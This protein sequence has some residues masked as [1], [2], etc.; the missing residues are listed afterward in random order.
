MPDDDA[1][2]KQALT[3]GDITK[4]T[5]QLLVTRPTSVNGLGSREQS[6]ASG[7]SRVASWKRIRTPIW[8]VKKPFDD[9]CHL[10]L[11]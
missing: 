3:G 1:N 9:R 11:W 10:E 4:Y 5:N 7:G 6:V 8:E 2:D